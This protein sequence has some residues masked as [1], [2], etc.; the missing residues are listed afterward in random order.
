MKN[1]EKKKTGLFGMGF[2]K[3]KCT[4]SLRMDSKLKAKITRLS[5]ITPKRDFMEWTLSLEFKVC[6]SQKQEPKALVYIRGM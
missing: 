2:Q 4:G 3:L 5:E 6:V 1:R